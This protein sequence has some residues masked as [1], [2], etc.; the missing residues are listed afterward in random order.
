MTSGARRKKAR[1]A[2]PVLI[3]YFRPAQAEGK[4][5]AIA[6]LVGLV[7]PGAAEGKKPN[8]L[9]TV[10]PLTNIVKNVGARPLHNIVIELKP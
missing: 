1:S 8:V 7:A 3:E 9:T 10:A 4:V 5:W 6:L 2:A